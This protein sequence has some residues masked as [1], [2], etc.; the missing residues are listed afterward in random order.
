MH[1]M[2][3]CRYCFPWIFPI[4]FP[5][6]FPMLFWFFFGHRMGWPGPMNRFNGRYDDQ[7]RE[8]TNSERIDQ[9]KSTSTAAQILDERL[10]RGEINK[11][12][13]LDLK[14]TLKA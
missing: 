10:A 1:M 2:E 6:I 3:A 8:R 11:E 7:A 5:I 14:K 12:E 13:Y 9:G 4:L